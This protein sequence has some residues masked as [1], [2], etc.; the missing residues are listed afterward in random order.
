M[1]FL[2]HHRLTITTLSPVHIGCNETYEPT[3]YVIDDDALYEFSPFDAV[4]VLDA[5]ERKKLQ[6]IVDRKP[7]AE[8]LKRVQRYFYQRREALLAISPHYLPVGEGVAALYNSRIGQIAQ[9]E[10]Q[11]NS[12]INKLE[13][14]RTAYHSINRLP[15]FPGSSLKGAIRTAL[16]DQVNQGQKLSN[17][18]EK[19]SE[20][21]QRLFGYTFHDMHKDPM[22]LITLADAH[23]QQAELSASKIY[24]AVNRKK[25]PKPTSR[26]MESRAEK[27]GM[28][29]LVE[30]VPALRYQ[31]LHGSM[32]LHNVD[33]VKRHHDKLP[34]EKFRWSII[35]IAKACNA[36]YLPQLEKEQRLLEQL[37]YADPAWL[38]RLNAIQQRIRHHNDQ[39][40]TVFLLRVGQHSGAEATTLN[41]IR[42]IG[43]MKGK[44]Q[45]KEFKDEATTLWLASN[46]N[47]TEQGM[48]TFGWVLVEIDPNE[49]APF[50]SIVK[51]PTQ[52]IHT[53]QQHHQQ[54]QQRA[55]QEIKRQ[56]AIK[57][58]QQ[59]RAAE[60]ER[61]QREQ[62][63]Q[64]EA[65]LAHTKSKLSPLAGEFFEQAQRNNWQ[66][67]KNAFWQQWVIESWLDKLAEH[68]D[69]ELKQQM[70]ELM[71][72]HFKGVMENPDKTKGRKN[73]P[74]YKPRV[75]NVAK[76]LLALK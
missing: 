19:N 44:G 10:S 64:Q 3:N 5:D 59:Q 70:Y 31:C 17:S 21:Q 55:L 30:C 8:M 45:K 58:E 12:V 39:D 14:E 4:Q 40:P 20:L 1:A 51:Q 29:Q 63:R 18:R 76:R 13:I 62:Q 43:I 54:K 27:G 33:S 60:K 6:T 28:Y 23:W 22:R 50:E 7:D 26:L 61:Q 32:T 2:Q 36:F 72:L 65:A 69:A 37:R 56:Q 9:R 75:I 49:S 35:D 46:H 66:N 74:A 53:W 16:L 41:G 71:R 47:D 48:K 34:A 67:N 52:A 68:P 11:H 38:E 42:S 25:H 24:F 57:Q 73:K 15:F